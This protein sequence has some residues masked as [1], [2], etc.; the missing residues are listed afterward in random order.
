[1][2]KSKIAAALITGLLC[3]L[4][5]ELAGYAGL[6]V[7]AGFA[8][9]TAYFASGSHRWKGL[10]LTSVCMLFGVLCGYGM[11]AFGVIMPTFGSSIIGVGV[12][13]AV[14]VAAGSLK[15][16]SFVP[17]SFVGCYTFFAINGDLLVLVPSLLIGAVLGLLCDWLPGKLFPADKRPLPE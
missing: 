12:L 14:I 16:L 15:W 5:A 6:S 17:G 3:G 1:M 8:G 10:S 9:C 11:S 7:W 2:D 13:V 4:W